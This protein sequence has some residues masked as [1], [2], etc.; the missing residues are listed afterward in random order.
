M[1][2][3]LLK[4]NLLLIVLLLSCLNLYAQVIPS[5]G[6]FTQADSAN[7]IVP[8]EYIRLANTKM[9]ERLCLIE[10]NNQKDS[11]IISYKT[12]IKEQNK[13]ITDYEKNIEDY[14]KLNNQLSKRLTRQKKTSLVCGT[15]A[16]AAIL[17]IVLIGI[18]R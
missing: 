6:I 12:Y 17:T 15:V 16:G 18:G 11:I 8:I 13:I 14:N 4:L 2:K 1:K 10:E 9:I 3:K 7:V 5:T